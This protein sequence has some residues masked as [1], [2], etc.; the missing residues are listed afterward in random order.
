MIAK[1]LNANYNFC[2]EVELSEINRESEIQ[3]LKAYRRNWTS[4]IEWM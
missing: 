4:D 1:N 2:H 3:Y